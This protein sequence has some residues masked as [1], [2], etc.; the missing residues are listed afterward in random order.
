MDGERCNQEG[1]NLCQ[2]GAAGYGAMHWWPKPSLTA[3]AQCGTQS[4]AYWFLTENDLAA[5]TARPWP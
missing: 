5:A 1:C 2:G 3:H 4:L